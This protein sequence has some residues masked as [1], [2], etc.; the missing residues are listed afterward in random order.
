MFY[1]ITGEILRRLVD[2]QSYVP[3]AASQ[4]GSCETAFPKMVSA[5]PW[6]HHQNMADGRWNPWILPPLS[7]GP[8]GSEKLQEGKQQY[9]QKQSKA[10][11][12]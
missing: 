7:I 4:A 12:N 9:A 8:G 2:S 5:A 10:E 3:D 11:K 1:P 6:R